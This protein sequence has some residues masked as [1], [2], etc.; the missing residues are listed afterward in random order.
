M[1]AL[2]A[3]ITKTMRMDVCRKLEM[4]V[5]KFVF[6]SPERSNIYYEVFPSSEI[7]LDLKHL[8]DDL[9]Q[10][11]HLTPRVI[12]YCRSLNVCADLYAFFLT[13]LGEESYY[14]AGAERISDNRLFGIY[15][16]F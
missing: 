2:T 1:I 9:H 5:H 14:P 4:S 7:E 16:S 10:N 13:S 11:K 12:I 15:V 6:A 3:T 8:V